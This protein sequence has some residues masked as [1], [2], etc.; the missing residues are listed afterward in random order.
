MPRRQIRRL[1]TILVGLASLFAFHV[2]A[3]TADPILNLQTL[4]GSQAEQMFKAGQLTSVQLVRAYLARIAAISKAGPGL[5]AVTQINPNALTDAAAADKAR[6]DGKDL[7]PAMGLPILLKDI[8]DA[9]PMFTS[10]G[11]WALR[12][13][14]A[15]DSGVAAELKAHGVVIL[16]KLGLSEWANSFGSQPSG[17]SN[18]TGQVLNATD[19]AAGPSGSSSGSGA[20]AS[21]GLSTLTIGTET[22]GSIISPSTAQADVGLR[23]TVGLVPGYGIAPIDVSQDTAGPMVRNVTDAAMTLQSIAEVPGSNPTASQEYLDVEGPNAFTNG[24]VPVAPFTALPDYMS[25]ISSTF[26]QGKR[27]GFN[28]TTCTPVPPAT[29][30]TLSVQQQANLT[31]VNALAAAG[32]IMV[33]DPLTTTA[34]VPANPTGYEQHATIDE[35]YKGLGPLAPVQSLAQEVAIDNTNPQEATKDGN[36]AHTNESLVDITPGGANEMAFRANLPIRK[37][38]FHTAIDAM[39]NCP[40]AGVTVNFD[41]AN[42]STT[43][44]T[45]CPSGTVNPVIAVIGATPGNTT[46]GYPEMVVPMGYTPTQRRPI[47]VDINGGAYDERNIIGVGYVMEQGTQLRQPVGQVDPASYRCARTVPPEP[48]ASR[49]HCNPDYQSI[50]NMIGGTPTILPFP[51]E[52]TSASQLEAMMA[53]GTLT[54]VALVKAE[55]SRIALANANGP[56]VQSIRNI[57]PG[58]IADA[59]LS[60]GQ[61]GADGPRGPLEGIPVVVDD[62][63]D[64]AG[65]PTS[66]G[67]IALQD[68]LPAAD[69]KLVAKLKAAGAIVLGD[70]NTTELGGVFDPNMPQG[71]SSLGGQALLPSDTNKSPGGSSAGSAAAVSA[72]FAPLSVGLETGTDGAQMITPAG[73]SGVVALKP[74]VGLISRAGVMPV[75][76]SQ[77][78][79]GPMGQT[80]TDVANELN[81]LA[82]P[83]PSDP[84]TAGQPATLPNY[85]AG[86]ATATLASKRIAVI[87]TTTGPGATAPYP[88]AVFTLGN[89]G[90]QVQTVT[91]PTPSPNPPSIVPSE[92]KR[93]LNTYLSGLPGSGAKSLQDII[94]YNIANPVEGLKFQQNGLLAAQAID[95]TDP[96]TNSTYQTN[97]TT[98]KA[99]NQAVIDGILNSGTPGDGSDDRTAIM[100]PSGSPLVGIADRAGYPVLTVP[101]GYGVRDSS[102]GADP[103]GV[104]FIGGAYSEPELLRDAFAFEKAT[105]I[106]AVGPPYFVGSAVLPGVSGAPSETNQSMWRCVPGSAFFHPYLCNAGDLQSATASGATSTSVETGISGTVAPTLSLSLASPA[107]SFG[108]FVPGTAADYN[109]SVTATLTS[110]AGNATLSIADPSSTAPGHLINGAYSLAQPVQVKATNAGNPSTVFAPLGATPLALLTYTGPTANDPITIGFKQSIGANEALRTGTYSKTLLLTASTTNP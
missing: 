81:V 94:N 61:R 37:K 8:V 22:S 57:N 46:A 82:G 9:A 3:A 69:A 36:S 30:C 106:R 17:F 75:A 88:A 89:A 76:K 2:T 25:A 91:I 102:T 31:A 51:L 77:D 101:A 14:F 45:T 7:G 66:G 4:T 90:T 100:V 108:S 13:S 71:Y 34:T 12:A 23:P 74:T 60:D 47:G 48:F 52:T 1:L 92:F 64:I 43:G 86:L 21:A 73:N 15:P 80:V 11:D 68:S 98:G 59:T 85:T 39:M 54:S 84:A 44:M 50:L 105:A 19:T 27:I 35:Y 70:T 18:L 62:S 33:P 24:D 109:A 78:A 55:L 87:S 104:N 38:A 40:G 56:A 58:A 10:A 6:A 20:A 72:G 42:P 16:G 28:S 103:I 107:P 79:P 41:P 5:N 32:A 83:D 67:S 53:A 96:A 49:G 99:A 29:T 93:D 97:L 63:M 110:S 26:V 95:L 65:L